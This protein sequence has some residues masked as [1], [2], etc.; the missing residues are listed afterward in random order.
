MFLVKSGLLMCTKLRCSYVQIEA[1]PGGSVVKKKKSFCQCRRPR[2][3][4]QVR[5]IPWRS[6]RQPTPVF[7]PG[8]WHDRGA[9]RATVREVA[10]SRTGLK[11]L[12]NIPKD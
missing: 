8:K 11:R 7:L 6:K 9:W 5:K 2:F 1:F 10:K 12:N 3:D 4:T